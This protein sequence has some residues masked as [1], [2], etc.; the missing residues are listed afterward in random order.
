MGA[1]HGRRRRP[2]LEHRGD[3]G[4]LPALLRRR[5]SL[6]R[7]HLPGLLARHRAASQPTSA[8][9]VRR[10]NHRRSAAAV[11]LR[12]F[13]SHH[14]AL[15][16]APAGHAVALA[17]CLGCDTGR[18]APSNEQRRSAGGRRHDEQSA[19]GCNA[20]ARPRARHRVRRGRRT[21]P[22]PRDGDEMDVPSPVGARELAAQA[23][24]AG[25]TSSAFCGAPAW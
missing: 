10:R 13:E 19:C 18:A 8:P 22:S 14:R 16:S 2:R 9:R 25:R 3:D 17:A 23:S 5:E 21:A 15:G 1:H 12:L 7:L 11:L 20:R 4:A 24:M 6:A